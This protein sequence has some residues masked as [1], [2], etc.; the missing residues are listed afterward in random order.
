LASNRKQYHYGL[1]LCIEI[2]LFGDANDHTR[3]R[4]VQ[5]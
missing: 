2:Q 4:W 5:I 3:G 1:H